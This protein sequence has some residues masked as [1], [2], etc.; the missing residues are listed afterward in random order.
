MYVSVRNKH[1]TVKVLHLTLRNFDGDDDTISS[2]LGAATRSRGGARAHRAGSRFSGVGVREVADF[3]FSACEGQKPPDRSFPI[4]Y[5]TTYHHLD[6]L[7]DA[8]VRVR[9]SSDRG[10]AQFRHH[11]LECSLVLLHLSQ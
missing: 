11:V 2:T 3:V 10:I 7:L 8:L 6:T 5:T 1:I 9:L 4:Q